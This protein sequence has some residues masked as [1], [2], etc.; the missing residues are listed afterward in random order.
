ML[1]NNMHV[2]TY[3]I[4][5]KTWSCILVITHR[6]HILIPSPDLLSWSVLLKQALTAGSQS[7]AGDREQGAKVMPSDHPGIKL[8]IGAG[9][10]AF[11][12]LH[13]DASHP[14]QCLM[15]GDKGH[16]PMPMSG[17]MSKYIFVDGPHR[18]IFTQS[19]GICP[20]L[21]TTYAKSFNSVAKN[22]KDY[23]LRRHES[24]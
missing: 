20:G 21:Y 13:P 6:R 3:I 12:S 22:V 1:S 18:A 5:R 15:F 2:C 10:A 23:R 17:Q 7:N 11:E 16:A 14:N 19:V 4:C 9:E 8:R 24:E